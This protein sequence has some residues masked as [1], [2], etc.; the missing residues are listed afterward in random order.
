VNAAALALVSELGE[1]A[2]R[3]HGFELEES[4]KPGE[5]VLCAGRGEPIWKNRAMI[6]FAVPFANEGNSLTQIQAM[7]IAKTVKESS[8]SLVRFIEEQQP[9]GATP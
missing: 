6:A 2:K 1:V 8:D 9:E 3:E 4:G 7:A 5:F